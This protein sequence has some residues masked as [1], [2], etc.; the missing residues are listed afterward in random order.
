M[1]P[2]LV[3]GTSNTWTHV[4]CVW[5]TVETMKAR[6]QFCAFLGGVFFGDVC[7]LELFRLRSVSVS[8]TCDRAF[9]TISLGFLFPSL[10]ISS[11]LM[12]EF[13]G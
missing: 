10:I 7:F 1:F 12:R 11:V 13:H 5:L 2:R 9:I 6:T 8:F 3:F 4:Y